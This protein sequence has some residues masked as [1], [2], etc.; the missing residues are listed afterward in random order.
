MGLTFAPASTAV[1]DG[2]PHE[3]FAIASSANATIREFGVTLG[4]ATLTAVF[5]GAGGQLTPTGYEGAVGPAL[6]TAAVAVGIATVAAFF[7]PT[8]RRKPAT[9]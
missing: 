5:L 3:D 7:V 4:V 1:L 9:D 2:L 8:G 6:L